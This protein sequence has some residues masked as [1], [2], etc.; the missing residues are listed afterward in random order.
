M[1]I[2]KW[3]HK[4]SIEYTRDKAKRA[5][6]RKGKSVHGHKF[7]LSANSVVNHPSVHTNSKPSLNTHIDS[8]LVSI[9]NPGKTLKKNPHTI[10]LPLRVQQANHFMGKVL[11]L[12]YGQ[13]LGVGVLPQTV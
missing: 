1:Q 2:D 9:A 5:K 13:S 10:I 4:E 7:K 12:L 3:K 6:R 8:S 11:T